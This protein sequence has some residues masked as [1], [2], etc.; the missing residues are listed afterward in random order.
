MRNATGAN[1]ALRP[2]R[3]VSGEFRAT[4][5]EL[6]RPSYREPTFASVPSV[7]ERRRHC[8]LIPM[9]LAPYETFGKSPWGR[10]KRPSLTWTGGAGSDLGA[11]LVASLAICQRSNCLAAGEG[12]SRGDIVW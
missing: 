10:R 1:G 4:W 7:P 5:E 3:L 8:S 11:C 12:A 9:A 2:Q 6:Q